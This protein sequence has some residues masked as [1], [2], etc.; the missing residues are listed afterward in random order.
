M[1]SPHV[2]LAAENMQRSEANATQT[3]GYPLNLLT[4]GAH[5]N[6]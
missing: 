6:V 4:Q 2:D 3:V 1:G 5:R